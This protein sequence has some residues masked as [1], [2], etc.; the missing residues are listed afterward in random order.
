M[1]RR[2]WR[3]RARP[4]S[5]R[6]HVGGNARGRWVSRCGWR[7]R[8][9]RGRGA[10]R[11]MSGALATAEPLGRGRQVGDPQGVA[12][13]SAALEQ[14]QLRAEDAGG[15][16]GRGGAW[17]PARP[18]SVTAG[19]LAQQPGQLGDI[20]GGRGRCTQPCPRRRR[21]RGD[22]GPHPPIEPSL[23]GGP[24]KHRSPSSPAR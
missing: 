7:L 11:R 13:P 20:W 3:R 6:D 18:S 2:S 1:Y 23:A 10:R 17:F 5:A 19:C 8:R 14:G 16:A 21:R 12:Q 9:G 24:K 15:S 22:P 4:C